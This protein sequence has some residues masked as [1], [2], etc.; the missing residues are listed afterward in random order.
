MAGQTGACGSDITEINAN[1]M[2]AI[3]QA[4]AQK[5]TTK[6]NAYLMPTKTEARLLR[7]QQLIF[8]GI[9]QLQDVIANWIGRHSRNFSNLPSKIVFN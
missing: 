7:L 3:M 5:I 6:T 2:P 8:A 1:S 4:V 9:G